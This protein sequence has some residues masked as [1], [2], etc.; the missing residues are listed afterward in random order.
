MR[1][2]EGLKAGSKGGHGPIRYTV[3]D[4]DPGNFVQFIFSRPSGFH[5]YH[6]LEI[7][8]LET[9]STQLRHVIDM[10]T[11]GTAGFSWAFGIRW[12]HDALIE[13][14]F[15]KIEYQF[16]GVNKVTPWNFWVRIL[17][18]ILAAKPR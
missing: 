10:E 4:Y 11:K 16:S 7:N 14:A 3:E 17:R 5:G 15:D 8:A 12:L 1:L 2:K 9:G 18:K 6:R 13:D